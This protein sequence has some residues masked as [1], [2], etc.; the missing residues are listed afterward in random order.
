MALDLRAEVNLGTWTDATAYVYQRN[1]VQVTRG[2]QN[3]S[4]TLAPASATFTVNNRDGRW[5]VRN[6]AGAWYGTLVQN[7]PLRLSVPSSLTGIPCYL[8]LETDQASYAST[9]DVAALQITS[10]TLSVRADCKITDWTGNHILVAK[11]GAAGNAWAL[12][13]DPDGTIAFN[14]YDSGGQIRISVST[15]PVPYFGARI[16]VRADYNI[17]AQTITFYT[18]PTMAGS[19]TQLGA[20]GSTVATTQAAAAGQAVQAGNG[21]ANVLG[22]LGEIYEVQILSAGTMVANPVFTAQTPGATSFT[23]AQARTWTLAGTAELSGRAYRF[24]GELA[25]L[26]KAADPSGTDVYSDAQA[27]G[28]TR[29]L[30]QQQSPAASAMTRAYLRAA[31]GLAAYWPAEDGATA[32][33]IAAAAGSQPMGNAGLTMASFTGIP[34]SAAIPVMNGGTATAL[35]DPGAVTWTANIVRFLLAVPAGDD[36]NGAVVAR[37]YTGGTVARADLIYSTGGVLS[38][39]GYNA[40]GTQLFNSGAITF[41]LPALAACRVSIEL[42][43]SGSAV[44]YK[45]ATV[46]AGSTVALFFSGTTASASIGA[47]TGVAFGGGL[48]GSAM[49][50]FSVQGT[51]DDLFVLKN[52]LN[53]WLGETAGARFSRLCGEEGIACR[54]TGPPDKS[55]TMGYQTAQTISELLQECE[56]TDQ[57]LMTEPRQVLGLGYVT[58]WAL[59]NQ[60]AL[61]TADYSLAQPMPFSPV[62]DDQL[63]VNDVTFTAADGSAARQV[64]TTGPTSVQS[65][66]AGAGRFDTQVTVNPAADSQLASLASWFLHVRSAD[67]DRYPSIPFVM[68]RAE[69]P[70]QVGLVDTGS[71]LQIISTPA[72]VPPGPARQLV[73]GY[74][75]TFMPQPLWVI[76]VNGIPESPYETGIYDDPVYGRYESSGTTLHANITSTA[77]SLQAD[78]PAGPLWT[79]TAGHFPFDLYM[80]GER[81]TVTAISGTSSPQTFTITRSVNGVVRAHSAGETIRLWFPAYMR[82]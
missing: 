19:W 12:Y 24:H 44:A 63:L 81:L 18:A 51:F 37:L 57:G 16:A 6:P 25:A 42:T 67:E 61:V 11:E 14:H 79:T 41:G 29:R 62:S 65:P 5:T 48:S 27:S 73:A 21:Q 76:T 45:V 53:A 32:T 33:Q 60:P 34:G 39:Q 71:Y 22:T 4:A 3:Q 66:P 64:L 54:I 80:G 20:A 59:C 36:T 2:R 52:P 23:D 31:A 35:V 82:L 17:A 75:E 47:V 49:G 46:N 74:A 70:V 15:V 10:G 43:T 8:R 7:S 77:T 55:V 26:P 9:P 58:N 40:A 50:H 69:T 68:N 56:N 78:I 72:W 38:L 30:Q 28:I 1:P 13:T